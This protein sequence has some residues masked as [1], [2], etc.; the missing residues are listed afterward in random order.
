MRA[1]SASEVSSAARAA[2]IG[3][4]GFSGW[5]I[6]DTEASTWHL[7]PGGTLAPEAPGDGSV[8]EYEKIHITPDEAKHWGMQGGNSLMHRSR[9]VVTA[10][11]TDVDV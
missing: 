7:G 2:D 6:P 8:D 1:A 3:S 10:S 5:P 4:V 11:K 9:R